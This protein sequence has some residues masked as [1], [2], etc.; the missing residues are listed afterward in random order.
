MVFFNAGFEFDVGIHYIGN[1]VGTSMSRV[2]SDQLTDGQL[3]WVP[4]DETYD[5]VVIGDLDHSPI[6]VPIIGKGPEIF[7]KKLIEIFPNE[8][9][10]ITEFLEILKV[11]LI[12]PITDFKLI[13]R[14]YS[15]KIFLRISI[16]YIRHFDELH[17]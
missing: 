15:I 5:V 17:V 10:G 1:I 12:W 8:E 13:I 6:K 16:I 14:L 9:K 4:L 11:R 2:L 7:K 3:D